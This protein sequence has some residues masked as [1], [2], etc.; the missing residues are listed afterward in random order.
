MALYI[1]HSSTPRNVKFAFRSRT[2]TSFGSDSSSPSSSA[3]IGNIVGR[4]LD[5]RLVLHYPVTFETPLFRTPFIRRRCPLSFQ[6]CEIP[7]GPPLHPYPK[8]TGIF[9][10]NSPIPSFVE[11][12][13]LY[14]TRIGRRFEPPPFPHFIE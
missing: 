12:R 1:Y 9:L 2:S 8:R 6:N 10:P 13:G 7:S 3:T 11:I 4:F 5:F 14:R